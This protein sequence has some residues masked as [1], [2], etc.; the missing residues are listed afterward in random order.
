VFLNLI[1]NA[2][3]SI[4]AGAPE[5]N[6]VRLRTGVAPDG[7]V[8]VEVEDTGVGMPPEVRRRLFSPF[9]TTKPDGVGTGLGLSICHR[10]LEGLG[11]EIEVS[12]L[13]GRGTTFRVLLPAS[14][15][16]P[17]PL[18][19]T[20]QAAV[21]PAAEAPGP[22]ARVL[23]IDDEESVHRAMTRL[24]GRTLDVCCADA[25]AALRR[26][27]GGERFDLVLCDVAMAGIS[28]IELHGRVK[29]LDPG[30]AARIVFLS[31]G[32][33]GPEAKVFFSATGAAVLD[34]GSHPDELRAAVDGHLRTLGRRG[35]P[36]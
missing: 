10:I 30:Q 5:R 20:G 29:A 24:L 34:K 31:G 22:R 16:A 8:V 9:F 26:L 14:R 33:F 13:P 32:A 2:A 15:A 3:Q 21:A 25:H 19:G 7:R 18:A 23:V 36:A 28:G 27:E 35:P 4:K 17:A 12:S 6:E 11:G 1:V